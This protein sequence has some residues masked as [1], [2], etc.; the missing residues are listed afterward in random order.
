MALFSLDELG[1]LLKDDGLDESSAHLAREIATGMVQA[2]T[3]PLESVASTVVLPV[4]VDGTVE[5]PGRVITAVASV[6]VDDVAQTF[7]WRRPYPVVRIQDWTPPST[8]DDWPL[9]E[10]TYT[11]GYSTVP[12][13]A[14]AVALTVAARA[15]AN[16]RGVT[17]VRI[18]D[19]VEQ[20][21]AESAG[22]T[23]TPYEVAALQPLAAAAWVTGR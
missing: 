21:Q 2:I 16:P 11:H 5:L 10:I 19:Y 4:M 7:S 3:G 1:Y 22:V 15:Y 20:S 6:T 18:D 14:K 8:L 13:V 23:L 17:S 9:A 12:P